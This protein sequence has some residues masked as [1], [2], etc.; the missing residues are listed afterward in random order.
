MALPRPGHG[1]VA[2][3]GTGG[4]P[5]AG[6]ATP[7][8]PGLRWSLGAVVGTGTGLAPHLLHHVGLVVGAA[9]VSGTAGTALFCAAGLATMTPTLI[10]LRRR[11]DSWWAPIIALTAFAAM[12][13]L[14]TT[15]I[16]PWL[17]PTV[18]DLP[19]QPRHS[20]T[21]PGQDEHT[22]HHADTRQRLAWRN[23]RA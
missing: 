9:I 14:S 12:F 1:Y 5:T 7:R 19:R 20:P 2:E 16:G 23:T 4:H 21:T 3:P 17:R 15:V 8:G 6:S 22:R 18:E 13:T 11:F 10:R